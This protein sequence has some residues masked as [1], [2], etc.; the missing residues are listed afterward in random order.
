MFRNKWLKKI[1]M[2][3]EHLKIKNST[4]KINISIILTTVITETININKKIYINKEIILNQK[5]KPIFK[6]I[7][8]K[9]ETNKIVK[10]M[11]TE[12]SNSLKR[13]A[14]VI[15]IEIMII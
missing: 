11:I 7:F 15:A 13:T 9:I 10:M 5:N 12:T 8:P 2:R 4:T 3:T 1:L 6:N 14:T